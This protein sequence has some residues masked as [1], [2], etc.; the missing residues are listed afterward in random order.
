MNESQHWRIEPKI[1]LG[2]L[3][4]GMSRSQVDRFSSIYGTSKGIS[5]DKI[6]DDIL[7]STLAELGEGLIAEEKQE[8]LSVYQESG[9]TAAGE[10][11][12]RGDN[13]PLVLTYDSDRLVEI[14]VD[15]KVRGLKYRGISVFEE[16][17]RDVIKHIAETLG[18]NP[19][20]LNEEVAFPANF[21]FLFEFV[22][23]AGSAYAEGS[24]TDRSIIWR[25]GPREGGV[26]LSEYKPMK[27]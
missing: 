18:E 21:V 11:E 22:R 4:F 8:I 19:L 27:I 12:V 24:R 2:K 5:S 9:P 23:E 20:I 6:P 26:D 14:L 15:T 7:Q 25:S 17:P 1:G 3:R 10:T 16:R 13:N